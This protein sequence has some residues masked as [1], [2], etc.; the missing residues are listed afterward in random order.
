MTDKTEGAESVCKCGTKIFCRKKPASGKF[1]EKL[2][3]Q[4]EDGK[5]HY[6]Y[7]FKTKETTCN[8]LEESTQ[9]TMDSPEIESNNFQFVTPV[10]SQVWNDILDKLMEFDIMADIRFK[11]NTKFDSSNPAHTGQI[12]N[13]AFA[14][15]QEI[16]KRKNLGE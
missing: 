12:K 9:Q 14:I 6:N 15:Q 2:Q 8:V 13:W 16:N 7:D 1:P 3:W 5:A 11:K 4:N 10:E